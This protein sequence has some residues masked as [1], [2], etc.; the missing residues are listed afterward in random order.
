MARG[1]F[2][3]GA[4]SPQNSRQLL[5]PITAAS[6]QFLLYTLEY[7]LVFGFYLPI[8]L[9]AG[10]RGESGVDVE[11]SAILSCCG[12]VELL[13]IVGDDDLRYPVTGDDVPP[14]ELTNL[15]VRDRT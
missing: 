3:S 12:T 11:A 13:A 9:R 1:F 6:L 4:A 8:C 2:N 15:F 7:N 14:E 5:R 10:D